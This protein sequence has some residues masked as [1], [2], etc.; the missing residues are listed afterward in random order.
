[1]WGAIKRIRSRTATVIAA[2]LLV[3]AVVTGG[4]FWQRWSTEQLLHE[5]EEALAAR[6]YAKARDR[7]NRYLDRRPRDTRVHILAARAARKLKAYDEASAHLARC[8]DEGATDEAIGFELALID[9]QQGKDAPGTALRRRAQVGDEVGL[10]I[11]EVVIQ[12]DLDTSRLHQALEE[13]NLYLVHRPD[14]L[15]ALL[16]RGF[17]WERFLYYADALNDYRRAVSTHPDSELARLRLADNLLISGSPQEAMEQY[18]WLAERWPDRVE[19]RFGLARCKRRL[20]RTEEALSMLDALAAEHPCDGEILWERGQLD[21]E[22]DRPAEAESWLRRALQIIPHDRR[23]SYSLSQCMSALNRKDESRRFQAR[24]AEIDADLRKLHEI[25]EQVFRKPNDAALR[26]EGGLIF[27]R[28]GERR[29]GVR[30]LK[31]A[32]SLD[33]ACETARTEL[34]KI[35]RSAQP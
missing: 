7:F 30:W 27:I 3:T 23:V 4:V 25:R 5:G 18:Q 35:Q 20:G 19:V 32:L 12:F 24:V 33:P 10:A 16:G 13:L 22:N 29:E 8:R 21:L 2:L 17:V 34:A 28:N 31:M 26:C 11:L 6:D 14:D 9:V 1:M 15:Q